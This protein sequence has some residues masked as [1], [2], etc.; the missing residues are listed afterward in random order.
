MRTPQIGWYFFVTQRPYTTAST[1][2]ISNK[3]PTSCSTKLKIT[4]KATRKRKLDT[5]YLSSFSDVERL[6]GVLLNALFFREHRLLDPR[7]WGA[8]LF[9]PVEH[10]AHRLLASLQ[11]TLH[12]AVT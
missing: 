7:L 1:D 12:C 3:M 8:G 2:T 6:E 11:L 10:L 9:K 4:D 5:T